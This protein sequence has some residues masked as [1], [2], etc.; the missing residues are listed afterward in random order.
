[1]EIL[2]FNGKKRDLFIRIDAKEALALIVSLAEQ[3]RSGSPNVRRLE[4]HD[5]AGRYLSIAV[6]DHTGDR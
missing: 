5:A 4:S 2:E 6:Q 3:M 1:M